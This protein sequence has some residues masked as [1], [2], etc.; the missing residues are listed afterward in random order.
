[1]K[2]IF[3]IDANN[4]IYRS[5]FAIR[6]FT[7][8][9][10]EP[11]NAIFGFVSTLLKILRDYDPEYIAVAF[12][13]PAPTFRHA[14]SEQYKITRKPM[15]EELSAQIPVIKELI[16]SFGII[17]IE[18]Q[19][20]EADDLL[21][22]L[23][24][25]FTSNDADIFIF[26]GDKDIL[27]LLSQH[28]M[29]INPATWEKLDEKIFFEKYGF[30]PQN[31][32]DYLALCGDASD[33]IPGVSGIGEKGALVLIKEFG[34]IE[35]LYENIE[36]IKS[37]KKELLLSGKDSAF[38]SKKLVQLKCDV[39]LEISLEDIKRKDPQPD[40]IQQI[41]QKLEFKKFESQIR[42][43]F[44]ADSTGFSSQDI[45]AI[46]DRIFD[47]NEIQKNPVVFEQ[48][49]KDDK[50]EKVGLNIKE[51]IKML[52][53]KNSFLSQ[54]YFDLGIAS[55][56]TDV[57][58]QGTDILVQRENY[59]HL[60]KSEG[61]DFLFHSIEM[62]LIEVIADIE[63]RG[64]LADRSYLEG[65]KKEYEKEMNDLQE[66][67]YS[68]AGEVFNINSP[69]QVANILFER[70][71][72]PAKR[73]TKS[74]YSTD[75][76]VL[77]QIRTKHRIVDLILQYR[78]LSKLCGTYIDGF[79]SF[80]NPS[81]SRIHPEYQQAV[82]STG[83][84]ACRNPNLQAIPVRTE[85]GGR[86]R[87]VFIAP[88]N[89]FLYAFDYNQIELR[90]LA[91]FSK[92]PVLIESFRKGCDIHLET[93]RQLFSFENGSLFESQES[94]TY[95]RIA[96]TIN[97]GIIYGMNSYGLAQRLGCSREEAQTFIDAYFTK[98]RKVREYIN[99]TIARAEKDGYVRTLFGRKRKLPEIRS[100][101]RNQRE[102]AFRVAV[103]MP[104]QGTA[105]ELIKLA[106]IKIYNFFKQQNLKSGM[107][108]QIHDE[109]VFEI[110]S[111]ELD[112]IDEIRCTM[113]NI[114]SLEVPLRV[115]VQRGENYLEMSEI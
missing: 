90:V 6:S 72:L 27:Q 77:S 23:A 70:L 82:A 60:L 47:F 36:K 16:K 35:N 76:A 114:C 50:L 75:S 107:I 63:M 7:T 62:P 34:T 43:I 15:P 97:F 110:Y 17:S 11:T 64:I 83:R 2:K 48:Y 67:I 74:G 91:H 26:S 84:L 58:V 20:F 5:F 52:A 61:M 89:A 57:P 44:N 94:D 112:I 41:F 68:I 56:L 8:S 69:S 96:K 53:S 24:R 98:F 14:L 78:E 32:V 95:R 86:L 99:E 21:A 55:F 19:S 79:S 71:G 54:P 100:E 46:G 40:R 12:D 30:N 29:V 31:I 109:L 88:E 3:L 10:G 80:I 25:K 81:D 22:C 103:N 1:M 106:M 66:K 102:F 42:E 105:S 111:D 93:A 85:K 39:N 104:V 51:K 59:K 115:N 45:L 33:N 13:T 113:E 73:K 28:I 38:L 65:L 18:K 37:R 9:T 87:K 101:N 92:D 49:L 108:L 4:I